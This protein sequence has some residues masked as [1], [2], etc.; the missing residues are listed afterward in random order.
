M[1]LA[2]TTPEVI[3]LDINSLKT[4]LNKINHAIT[5][6]KVVDDFIVAK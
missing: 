2:L 6:M 3:V 1:V 4:N 5:D